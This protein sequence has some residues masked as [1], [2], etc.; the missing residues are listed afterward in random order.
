MLSVQPLRRLA[1]ALGVLAAA[2]VVAAAAV[3]KVRS[4]TVSDPQETDVPAA[5]NI[6]Q[7]RASYDDKTGRF[8]IAVRFY[9]PVT[10]P[11]TAADLA[12]VEVTFG[13]QSG[14]AC[15]AI[16]PNYVLFQTDTSP[17]RRVVVVMSPRLKTPVGAAKTVTSDRR[18]IRIAYT[19]K[20]L[21]ALDLRCVGV[22]TRVPGA[23]GFDQLLPGLFF[24]GPFPVLSAV[25]VVPKLIGKT[26]AQ[27]RTALDKAGCVVGTVR[28]VRTKAV[29]AGR[30]VSQKPIA[31]KKLA[32]GGSV[33]LNVSRGG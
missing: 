22:N 19:S 9:A 8:S 24:P 10:A 32:I 25:C 17:D 14:G 21:S 15:T 4:G 23:A 31:G 3:A 18:E 20:V 13:P 12:L 1:V 26:L 6:E 29:R 16:K 33:A 27:A 5:R 30:V 7:V 11:A 2:L 28:R